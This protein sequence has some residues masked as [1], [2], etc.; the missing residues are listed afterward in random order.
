MSSNS[1]FISDLD[2]GNVA[3]EQWLGQVDLSSKIDG[4]HTFPKTNQFGKS[5][6]G[7]SYSELG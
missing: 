4:V 5:G 1:E 7:N 3:F 6:L 2:N